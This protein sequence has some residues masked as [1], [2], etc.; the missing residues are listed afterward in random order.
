MKRSADNRPLL[1][2]FRVLTLLIL[3]V[4]IGAVVHLWYQNLSETRSSLTYIN[5]MLVQ[6]VR[7]TLKGHEL[8]LQGLGH[9][10]VR[11]G[12]LDDPER[13]RE[14]IER[15][16]LIDPGMA[17]FGLAR[18]DGQLVLVSGIAPGSPL[19]N[20][21]QRPEA[22]DSFAEV[23]ESRH[24]RT[25][26]PYYFDSLGRWVVPIRVAIRD[27]EGSI[28]AVMTAGYTIDQATTAWTRLALPPHVSVGLIRDDG[29]MLYSQPLPSLPRA[30]A[31]EAVYG[32][33]PNSSALQGA[34]RL[35]RDSDFAV[36][37]RRRLNAMLSHTFKGG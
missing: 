21:A 20:L 31:L 8:V 30:E 5:S 4:Y 35:K 36:L 12:S 26:R 14:L 6:G 23:L 10:L 16:Q 7:T 13:G 22:R 2:L 24:L 3:A 33:R 29:Y 11:L 9:E 27:P 25:G 32:N 28:L 15:M 18:A 17:G 1:G 37:S 34:A 19:P